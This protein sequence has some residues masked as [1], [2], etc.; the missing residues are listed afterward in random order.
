VQQSSVGTDGYGTVSGAV[1]AFVITAVAVSSSAR[2]QI[3]ECLNQ[4]LQATPCTLAAVRD[5]SVSFKRLAMEQRLTEA[6][7][8]NK[9]VLHQT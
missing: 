8:R 4:L 6:P 1:T 2:R 5:R 7:G 3:I 9:L